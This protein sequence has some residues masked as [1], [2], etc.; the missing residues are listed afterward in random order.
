MVV[1]ASTMPNS[2]RRDLGVIQAKRLRS[3]YDERTRP[4]ADVVMTSGAARSVPISLISLLIAARSIEW[5]GGELCT[6]LRPCDV[7]LRF[8]GDCRSHVICRENANREEYT[9]TTIRL[10]CWKLALVALQASAGDVIGTA[11]A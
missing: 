10:D 9:G 11:I 3:Q 6:D 4:R 5:G 1:W 2:G 7:S 8:C